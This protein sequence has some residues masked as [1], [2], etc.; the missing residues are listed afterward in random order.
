MEI[1]QPHVTVEWVPLVAFLAVGLTSFIV[2]SSWAA[3]PLALPLFISITRALLVDLNEASPL[4]PLLLATIGAVIGGTVF[5]HHCSPI[6]ETTVLSSASTSC[7]HLDHV[8]T[9]LPYALTVA[10]VVA[11]FGYVPVAYGHSPVVLLPLATIVLLAILQFGGRPAVEPAENPD[12]AEPAPAG[13]DAAAA[14]RPAPQSRANPRRLGPRKPSPFVRL[15]APSHRTS[16][17]RGPIGH[18]DA[19]S[20]GKMLVFARD[21]TPRPRHRV[22]SEARGASWVV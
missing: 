8:L 3:L 13:S 22:P 1:G 2:G 18:T 6:S 5:G 9:Q 21:V 16:G 19:R 10:V 12:A 17:R 4:H 20:F 7:S 15:D 11:L 14:G